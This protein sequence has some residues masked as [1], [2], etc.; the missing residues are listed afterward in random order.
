M[1][2]ARRVV[3]QPVTTDKADL[4]RL[5]AVIRSD[6]NFPRS[7]TIVSLRHETGLTMVRIRALLAP[8]VVS[9]ELETDVGRVPFRW[10]MR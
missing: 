10:T 6:R 5:L 9:G 2:P 8:M 1:P 4:D 7:A 3:R